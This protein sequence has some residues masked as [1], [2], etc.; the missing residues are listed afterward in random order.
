MSAYDTDK[1]WV[2]ELIIEKKDWLILNVHDSVQVN[3][4]SISQINSV[5]KQALFIF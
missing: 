4:Q 1:A 5:G 2:K 3:G